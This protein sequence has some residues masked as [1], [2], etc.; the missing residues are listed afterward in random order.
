MKV[1]IFNFTNKKTKIV[2]CKFKNYIET[3]FKTMFDTFNYFFIYQNFLVTMLFY[4]DDGI[5]TSI[6]ISIQV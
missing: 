3:I 4:Q 6:I 2:D 5:H 1:I